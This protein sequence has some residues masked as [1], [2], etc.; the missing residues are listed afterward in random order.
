MSSCVLYSIESKKQSYVCS[1]LR[2]KPV[3]HTDQH[4]LLELNNIARQRMENSLYNVLV[5]AT[6]L[7]FK[8][9]FQ[10]A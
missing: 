7:F 1:V 3:P 5:V 2:T 10:V 6:L 8:G 4:L 9:T